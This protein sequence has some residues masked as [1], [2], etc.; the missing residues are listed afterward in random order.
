[1][2]SIDRLNEALAGRSKAWLARELGITPQ[3]LNGWYM[4]GAVAGNQILKAA[5]ILNVSPDWLENGTGSK[6][7]SEIGIVKGNVVSVSHMNNKLMTIQKVPVIFWIQAGGWA[8]IVDDYDI[9]MCEDFV[10]TNQSV[11]KN[12]FA[13]TVKSDSMAPEFSLGTRIIVDPSTHPENGH[14]VIAKLNADEEATFKKLS[15]DGSRTYLVPINKQFPTLDVTDKDFN[16][17]GVVIEQI[18][19]YR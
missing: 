17:S 11:G 15:I 1:M 7:S 6:V 13:L 10:Y 3:N 18:K 19:S 9:G 5:R 14:F 2:N 12:A 16:I 8:S 4:R